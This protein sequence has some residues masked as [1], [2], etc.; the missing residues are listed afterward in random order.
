MGGKCIYTGLLITIVTAIMGGCVRTPQPTGRAAVSDVAIALQTAGPVNS[1]ATTAFVIAFDQAVSGFDDPTT[2]VQIQHHGT[3]AGQV[4][5]IPIDERTY[6]IAVTGVTGDGSFTLG[7]P[8]GAAQDADGNPCPAGLSTPMSVDNTPPQVAAI[9]SLTADGR[10]GVGATINV[11]ADFSEPVTL[12][13]G[14][15]TVTLN[16]GDQV[17]L[18]PFASATRVSGAFII[19][20]GDNAQPLDS[21]AIVLADGA[22]IKDAA[23]NVGQVVL[24]AASL[25]IKRQIVVDTTAPVVTINKILTNNPANLTGTVNDASAVVTVSLAGAVYSATN[26]GQGHWSLTGQTIPALAE[27]VYQATVVA[28]DTVGNNAQQIV[29]DTLTLDLSAPI[30][31]ITTLTTYDRTPNLSGAVNDDNARITVTL[32]G[33]TYNA[34]NNGNQTWSLSGNLIS[35]PLP[36]GTYDLVVEATDPAGNVGRDTTTNELTIDTNSPTVTVRK[37]TANSKTPTLSGTVS[38]P[39][40]VTVTVAGKTYPA[41]VDNQTPPNWT[42]DGNLISP[43]LP[44][45]AYEL[46]LTATDEAGNIGQD[47]V[48][49]ALMID[50]TPPKMTIQ[51]LVTSDL[52]PALQGTVDDPAATVTVTVNG[53]TYHALNNGGSWTLP[54]G[55]ID[56]PLAKGAYAVTVAATDAPGNFASEVAS[57][58]LWIATAPVLVNAAL[59]ADN[60]YIDLTFDQ[61]V[62]GGA[63]G[64]PVDA[65]DFV[66]TYARNDDVITGVIL[67]GVANAEGG[68][69]AGVTKVRANLEFAG[70]PST[71]QGFVR[72]APAANSVF[73]APGQVAPVNILGDFRLHDPANLLAAYDRSF[74]SFSSVAN[75]NYNPLD[76]IASTAVIHS[77]PRSVEFVNPTNLWKDHGITVPNDAYGMNHFTVVPNSSYK[78]S[79]WVYVKHNAVGVPADTGIQLGLKAA[80]SPGGPSSN[81]KVTSVLNFNQWTYIE[82]LLASPADATGNAWLVV[83]VRDLSDNDNTVFIDDLRVTTVP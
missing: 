71:G 58:G 16:T 48:P 44:D 76:A 43:P 53:N 51:P 24:P 62:Y 17:V 3:A 82:F 78:A 8:A 55:T 52:S 6:A 64:Q 68:D 42:V 79:A 63:A 59:A 14:P 37:V 56:P 33:Q 39:A 65:S 38:K 41:A 2:D 70:Q 67:R 81:E 20:A 9:D 66:L 12:A 40:Q 5:I 10:Y 21:A 54:A 18:Q 73:N 49:D 26:D 7:I 27:G 74:D 50:T 46:L 80:T 19:E 83:A 47:I 32:N 75:A 77:G 23:G 11:S 60:A 69:L 25:A 29:A 28:T 36:D 57:T 61:P 34:V 1:S 31:I 35:P 4:L 22:T 15:I 30:V 45:A 13:G 72:I